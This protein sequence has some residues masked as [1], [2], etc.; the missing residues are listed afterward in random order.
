MIYLGIGGFLEDKDER[1][2]LCHRA[3]HYTL[4]NDELFQRG[5]NGTLMRCILP[6]EGC[7]IL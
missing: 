1:E 6:D 5:T 4:V 2:R 7:V 3:G